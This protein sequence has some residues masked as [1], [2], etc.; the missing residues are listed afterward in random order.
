MFFGYIKGFYKRFV[1]WS[2]KMGGLEKKLL[3]EKSFIDRKSFINNKKFINKK[4]IL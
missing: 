4:K 3:I 1:L 2:S